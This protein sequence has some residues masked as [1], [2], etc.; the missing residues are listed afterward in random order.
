M[1][2]SEILEAGCKMLDPILLP[3][4]FVQKQI[5][6]GKGSGGCFSRCEYVRDER[7]IEL[8][9]RHSLGLVTYHVGSASASHEAYMH[10]VVEDGKN[11]YPGFSDDPLDGFRHLAHDLELFAR[12]FLDGEADQLKEAAFEEEQQRSRDQKEMMAL[13][14]GDARRRKTARERFRLKD[15]AGVV[16]QFEQLQYPELMSDSE[17][18]MLRIASIKVNKNTA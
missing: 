3:R 12:D 4:G 13:S 2:I 6:T 10:V 14:V 18:I 11:R 5:S 8:H 17:Q 15:Y 9:F 16:E 7:K 1:D